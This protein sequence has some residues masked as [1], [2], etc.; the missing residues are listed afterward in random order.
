MPKRN[1]ILQLL[2]VL[3]G[4]LALSA[5]LTWLLVW[6]GIDWAWASFFS[7]HH[8]PVYAALPGV[9]LGMVTPVAIP[10]WFFLRWR[11]KGRLQ[12]KRLFRSAAWALGIA[13]VVTTLLKIFTNRVDMEPFE[14]IGEVDF[15]AA[16]RFGL[17]QGAGFWESFAEGWP[18]GHT[19]TSLAVALAIRPQLQKPLWKHLHLAWALLVALSVSTAFHWLSDVVSGAVFAGLIG[20]WVRQRLVQSVE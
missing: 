3:T 17:L 11:W 12:D 19:M 7:D 14:P 1:A 8:A 5:G 10:L 13:Y 6:S 2:F 20:Y 18:S 16:F 4:G 15:S 9:L